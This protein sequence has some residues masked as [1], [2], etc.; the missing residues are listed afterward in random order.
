MERAV[1]VVPIHPQEFVS[2]QPSRLPQSAARNVRT[3]EAM[4]T[5]PRIV[6]T[7]VAAPGTG[8]GDAANCGLRHP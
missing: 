5:G 4:R 7:R 1:V 6:T 2:A 3:T 8:A